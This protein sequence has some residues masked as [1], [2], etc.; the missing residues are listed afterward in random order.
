MNI[1]GGK[2]IGKRFNGKKHVQSVSEKFRAKTK[3]S[4]LVKEEVKRRS[5]KKLDEKCFVKLRPRVSRYLDSKSEFNGV[6]KERRL[7]KIVI[8]EEDWVSMNTS[9]FDKE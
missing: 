9:R 6:G 4:T 2:M 8:R 3:S 1:E 7:N 5:R